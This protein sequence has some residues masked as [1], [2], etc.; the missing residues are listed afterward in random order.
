M[1]TNAQELF[2]FAQLKTTNSNKID[3]IEHGMLLASIACM[4]SQILF[5]IK[6]TVQ[7]NSVW[8]MLGL[9][10]LLPK[11]DPLRVAT[12]TRLETQ[13][14]SYSPHIPKAALR[15]LN[16]GTPFSALSS[17]EKNKIKKLDTY[18]RWRL[19]PT[20]ICSNA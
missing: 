18:L 3:K 11:S 15:V 12:A 10:E 5:L 14:K 19:E 9:N 8:A 17:Y 7:D 20:K 16:D 1:R 6:R 13:I 2:V 4:A